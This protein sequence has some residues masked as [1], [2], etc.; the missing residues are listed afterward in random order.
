MKLKRTAQLNMF[1]K[2]VTCSQENYIPIYGILSQNKWYGIISSRF[3]NGRY[4]NLASENLIM[5][6]PQWYVLCTLLQ[7]VKDAGRGII[8]RIASIKMQALQG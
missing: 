4:L 7:F 6:C 2:E 3:R 5:L 8:L 1:I